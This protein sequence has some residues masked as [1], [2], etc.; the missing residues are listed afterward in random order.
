MT[1]RR[2]TRYQRALQMIDAFEE[3]IGSATAEQL[4]EAAQDLLLTRGPGLGEI[5]LEWQE[6]SNS[7]KL[8]V[9]DGD[10]PAAV[11]TELWHT[12]HSCGPTPDRPLIIE[13]F[14]IATYATR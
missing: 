10:V 4:R 2:Y 6:A 14:S 13:P 8:M 12:I 7:L 5:A 3:S 11:G 9:D 1:N